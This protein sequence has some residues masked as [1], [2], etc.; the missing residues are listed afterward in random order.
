MQLTHQD[1]SQDLPAAIEGSNPVIALS[2]NL[3]TRRHQQMR[4]R[5]QGMMMRLA[6]E[7]GLSNGLAGHYESHIQGKMPHNFSGYSRSAATMS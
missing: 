5:E 4:R 7:I 2:R 6:S 3:F 1:I